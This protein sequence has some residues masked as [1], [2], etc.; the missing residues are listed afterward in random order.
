MTELIITEKPSAAL[1]VAAALADSKAA[2]K[3]N[4]AVF[5]VIKYFFILVVFTFVISFIDVNYT[6]FVYIS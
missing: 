1:K 2:K 3:K 4:S 6:T 5:L